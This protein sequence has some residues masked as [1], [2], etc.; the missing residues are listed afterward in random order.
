LNKYNFSDL[1]FAIIIGFILSI[2]LSWIPV[3]AWMIID[4]MLFILPN[5]SWEQITG[6]TWVIL[7]IYIFKN[8]S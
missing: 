8:N 3:L 6:I 7:T 2:L 5:L 4:S 1:S